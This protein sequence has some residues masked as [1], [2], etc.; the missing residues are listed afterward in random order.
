MHHSLIFVCLL[1]LFCCCAAQNNT[2]PQCALL[3]AGTAAT[4]AGCSSYS[5][6]TCVCT[7]QPFQSAIQP[8]FDGNCSTTE[9][10]TAWLYYNDLCTN[11][12]STTGSGSSTHSVTTSTAPG[13]VSSTNGITTHTSSGTITQTSPTSSAAT[14]SSQT[15]S[16]TSTSGALVTNVNM[17]RGIM[18]VVVGGALIL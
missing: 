9:Q 8:C 7:S 1:T 17:L 4:A 18:V 15:P 3:C 6:A 12:S 14:S 13:T 16:P 5:N 2:L 11:G 10:G